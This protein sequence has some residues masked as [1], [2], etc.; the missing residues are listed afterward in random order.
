MK[1]ILYLRLSVCSGDL[2]LVEHDVP[3]SGREQTSKTERGIVQTTTS[4]L[5]RVCQYSLQET[6]QSGL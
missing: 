3:S 6:G 1:H 4:H 5:G 2:V